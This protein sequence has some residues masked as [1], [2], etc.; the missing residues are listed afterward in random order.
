MEGHRGGKK[1]HLLVLG[2]RQL[3]PAQSNWR[4]FYN[5]Q[6]SV[7]P[8]GNFVTRTVQQCGNKGQPPAAVSP[9][10][11]TLRW[12]HVTSVA[13]VGFLCLAWLPHLIPSIVLLV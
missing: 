8:S 11:T 9:E 7:L 12:E 4:Q 1:N 6:Q 2:T 10:E 13:A 5:E 3:P